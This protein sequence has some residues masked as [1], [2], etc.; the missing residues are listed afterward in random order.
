VKMIASSDGMDSAD[1]VS[2]KEWGRCMARNFITIKPSISIQN[3]TEKRS[4][5]SLRGVIAAPRGALTRRGWLYVDKRK[6]YD[7]KRG[8]DRNRYSRRISLTRAF[9]LACNLK[10]PSLLSQLQLPCL[11]VLWNS[12]RCLL[13]EL[14]NSDGTA[15]KMAI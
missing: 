8:D 14:K 7:E 4:Q 1:W 10:E 11:S 15:S 6:D 12:I 9:C 5:L 2:F 13:T 3:R